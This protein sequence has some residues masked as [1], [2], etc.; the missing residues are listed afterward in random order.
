MHDCGRMRSEQKHGG[1]V[2]QFCE[3]AVP[4]STRNRPEIAPVLCPVWCVVCGVHAERACWLGKSLV[5]TLTN[6]VRLPHP[7]LHWC[8]ECITVRSLSNTTA[9][10]PRA[11]KKVGRH[12]SAAGVFLLNTLTSWWTHVTHAQWPR[13]FCTGQSRRQVFVSDASATHCVSHEESAEV[14]IFNFAKRLN[15]IL[16]FNFSEVRLRRRC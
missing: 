1:H 6:S 10:A 11:T 12:R 16:Y 3:K 5:L 2:V 4:K 7:S 8:A 9:R 14:Y 15:F 13:L